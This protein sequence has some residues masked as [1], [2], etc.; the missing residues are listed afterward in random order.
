MATDMYMYDTNTVE[1]VNDP[2]TTDTEFAIFAEDVQMTEYMPLCQLIYWV[3]EHRDEME[4][5]FLECLERERAAPFK[6][7]LEAEFKME[8]N[9]DY[10]VVMPEPPR[11][12]YHVYMVNRNNVIHEESNSFPGFVRRFNDFYVDLLVSGTTR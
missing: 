9:L 2:V 4:T 8:W 6:E 1:T 11:E 12:T 3:D 10:I 7:I 5:M